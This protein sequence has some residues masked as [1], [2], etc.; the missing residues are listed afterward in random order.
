[1]E[2]TLFLSF[3]E[4]GFFLWDTSVTVGLVQKF[5]YFTLVTR[6]GIHRCPMIDGVK[7]HV[8]TIR[9][10]G[11]PYGFFPCRDDFDG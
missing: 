2:L 6:H 3:S 4:C 7:K 8:L 5:L 1:M 11:I 10:G 9:N